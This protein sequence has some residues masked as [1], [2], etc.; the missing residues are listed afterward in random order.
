MG[1]ALWL[2]YMC[3]RVISI[4]ELTWLV[5]TEGLELQGCKSAG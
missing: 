5:H 3:R 2:P 4:N 1:I